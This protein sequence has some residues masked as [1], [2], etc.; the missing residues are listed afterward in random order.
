MIVVKI[1]DCS[2]SMMWYR[3]LIGKHVPF[4]RYS[5]SDGAVMCREPDGY[6]NIVKIRDA[7]IIELK[8]QEIDFIEYY[9]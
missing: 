7:E 5:L 1:K 4:V 2:D 8:D 3:D 9:V 6:S